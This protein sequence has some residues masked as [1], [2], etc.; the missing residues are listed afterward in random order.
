MK[1]CTNKTY[2]RQGEIEGFLKCGQKAV[3]KVPALVPREFD[4]LCLEDWMQE[5]E[6]L[7]GLGVTFL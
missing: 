7:D 2:V 5:G 6:E 3:V 1:T 4:C